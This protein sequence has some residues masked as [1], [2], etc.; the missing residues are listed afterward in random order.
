MSL[1]FFPKALFLLCVFDVE[2]PET[3]Y[4]HIVCPSVFPLDYCPLVRCCVYL[5]NENLQAFSEH[6]LRSI[7]H[8][9]CKLMLWSFPNLKTSTKNTYPNDFV[10]YIYLLVDGKPRKHILQGI[11][12]FNLYYPCFQLLYLH[13]F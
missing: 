7:E 9:T 10:L 6:V 13:T 8:K 4:N 11:V 12:R 1:I 2:E 5:H 3:S